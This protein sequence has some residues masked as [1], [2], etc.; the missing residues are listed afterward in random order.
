MERGNGG[1]GALRKRKQLLANR[2]NRMYISLDRTLT[3]KNA[4]FGQRAEAVVFVF[5]LEL[6]RWQ[7][8]KEKCRA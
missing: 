3:Q 4:P 6:S 5:Y 1:G 8:L 7:F 2:K